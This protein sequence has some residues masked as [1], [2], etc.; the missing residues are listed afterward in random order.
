MDTH[1]R[2]RASRRLGLDLGCFAARY[3][4]GFERGVDELIIFTFKIQFTS[5]QTCVIVRAVKKKTAGRNTKRWG[6]TSFIGQ[7]Q[8]NIPRRDG[9]GCVTLARSETRYQNFESL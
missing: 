8:I 4:A 6:P 7:V 1:D 9:V 5:Q 3:G 2:G